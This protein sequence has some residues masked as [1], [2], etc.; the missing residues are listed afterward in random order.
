MEKNQ[1]I[2]GGMGTYR[3]KRIRDVGTAVYGSTD[4]SRTTGEGIRSA[5]VKSVTLAALG[6]L[7]QRRGRG[8]TATWYNTQLKARDTGSVRDIGPTVRTSMLPT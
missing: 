5:R 6:G 8:F 7:L 2:H 4:S 3:E 1:K